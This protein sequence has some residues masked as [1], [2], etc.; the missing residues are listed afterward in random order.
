[1]KAK[2]KQFNLVVMGPQGSGKGTQA[3][4]LAKKFNLKYI[5]SGDMLR[6][7]ARQKT[8]FGKQVDEYINKEGKLVPWQWII[9]IIQ[10]VAAKLPKNKG[11]VFDGFARRL[12]EAKALLKILKK[13]GREL[14]AV[15][16]IKISAK[17]TMRRLS[18]R[19]ICTNG[20]IFI[21]GVNLKKS[22][23]KCPKC[24]AL[25]IQREDDKPKFIRERLKDYR[26]K[27]IPAIKYFKKQGL[28]I[29]ING[30]QTIQKVFGDIIRALKRK[31]P[32]STKIIKNKK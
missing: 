19:R 6:K 17:E 10:K 24:G 30:E 4:L 22:Q 16:L 2:K 15:I 31:N 23:K 7:I 21:L 32:E 12:P 5:G 29:E 26:E 28:L 3:K 18:N 27:T 13:V 1:M 11:I 14:T 8:P 25:I 20:H 9:K